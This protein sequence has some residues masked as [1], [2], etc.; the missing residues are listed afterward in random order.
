MWGHPGHDSGF[1][2]HAGEYSVDLCLHR[3][4]H[5]LAGRTVWQEI[6]VAKQPPPPSTF[7]TC[8]LSFTLLL[9]F[10][11]FF[12]WSSLQERRGGVGWK[13]ARGRER[14]REREGERRRE[15]KGS[16]REREKEGEGER[17]GWGGRGGRDPGSDSSLA[18]VRLPDIYLHLTRK[19]PVQ[20]TGGGGG[21]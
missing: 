11:F 21:T 6:L 3:T 13:R 4:C 14:E 1:K 8:F 10:L 19:F 5:F 20:L 18:G 15:G 9:L 12:L 7:P 17:E 2:E 16:A